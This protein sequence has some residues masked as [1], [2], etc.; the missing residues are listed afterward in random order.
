MFFHLY[1]EPACGGSPL[2]A[3]LHLQCQQSHT[4]KSPDTVL[5]KL[6]PDLFLY[7]NHL[8]RLLLRLRYYGH[9]I[10]AQIVRHKYLPSLYQD[11]SR[12]NA[13]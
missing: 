3:Y 11:I 7:P 12:Q 4:A 8:R 9:I 13:P 5:N 2:I 6:Y 1:R 10:R